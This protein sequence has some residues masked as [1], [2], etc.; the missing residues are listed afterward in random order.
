MDVLLSSND[1]EELQEI[2]EDLYWSSVKAWLKTNMQKI[3]VMF[4]HLN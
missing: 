2:I 3:K 1:F 4:S